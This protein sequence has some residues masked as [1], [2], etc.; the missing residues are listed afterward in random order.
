[1]LHLNESYKQHSILKTDELD[2]RPFLMLVSKKI[3]SCIVVRPLHQSGSNS[4]SIDWQRFISLAEAPVP[5][6]Q[7]LQIRNKVCLPQFLG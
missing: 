4:I 7:A 2:L 5:G 6:A 3:S 1:M